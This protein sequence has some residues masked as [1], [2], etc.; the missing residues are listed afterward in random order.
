MKRLSRKVRVT[1]LDLVDF[2]LE[3]STINA[4]YEFACIHMKWIFIASPVVNFLIRRL[5][6][7]ITPPGLSIAIIMDGN[8]RYA[9]SASISKKAGHEMGY[10]HVYSIL[11]CMKRAKCRSVGFFAFGMKNFSRSEEEVSDIM[12]ILRRGLEKAE[13]SPDKKAFL[14]ALGVVGDISAM[15][16]EMQ[17]VLLRI[18]STPQKKNCYLFLAYSSLYEYVSGRGD[19]TPEK[20]DIIIRP[21]GEKRLS[22]FLLCNSANNST[23]CFVS[24]KWPVLSAGHILM[25]VGK[26]VL[27]SQL[28]SEG[29][30]GA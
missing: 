19:G 6:E 2:L 27:E 21:G 3:N 26:Y 12:G 20:F 15:P 10:A 25:A 17:P 7:A 1:L 22:D 16:S 29:V 24:S 14:D 23:L 8:R 13:N 28:R 4:A 9:K 18:R 11:E 5:S 30:E